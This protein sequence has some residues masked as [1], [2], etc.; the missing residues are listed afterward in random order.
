MIRINLL[1]V[2]QTRKIEAARREFALA[3]AG[4]IGVVVI[5]LGV[6]GLLT[7]QQASLQKDNRTLQA[8]IDRL[9][10]DVA[11]VD[12]MEKFRAELQRKL[13]VIGQLR[14]KKTGPVHMLD[15]LTLSIPERCQLTGVDEQGGN[16]TFEGVAVTNEVISQF[17]RSLEASPYYEMVYL[18]NIEAM[19]QKDVAGTFKKFKITARLTTPKAEAAK[20]AADAKAGGET[21]G[22]ADAKAGD[23]K[24][25]DAKPAEATPAE[26]PKPG[27]AK[28]AGGEGT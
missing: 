6:W 4:G 15:E 1:P 17:L 25:A 5:G 16:V 28:P 24:P 10:A 8:E 13:D 2:R 11:K 7:V 20:A 23:A 12:E 9:A 3:V 21:Q 22:A 18:Q 27:D 26:A 19:S 14:E